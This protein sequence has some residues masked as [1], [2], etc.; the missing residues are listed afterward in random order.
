VASLDGTDLM[1]H[2]FPQGLNAA[3]TLVILAGLLVLRLTLSRQ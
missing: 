3:C 2:R 1:M